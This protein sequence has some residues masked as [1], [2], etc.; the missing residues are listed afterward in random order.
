MGIKF[1]A[2]TPSA[3]R[4]MP[5]KE[6][7]A[8]VSTGVTRPEVKGGK[9]NVRFYKIGCNGRSWPS[10][11]AGV[12]GG[13]EPLIYLLDSRYTSVTAAL[14]PGPQDGGVMMNCQY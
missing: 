2:A 6:C 13:R 12:G 3:K 14:N 8:I 11:G 4:A 9:S 7:F 10:G 1:V 5:L